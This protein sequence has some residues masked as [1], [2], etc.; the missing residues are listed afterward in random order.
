MSS[1]VYIYIYMYILTEVKLDKSYMKDTLVSS[2]SVLCGLKRFSL[3]K[4][5]FR[6]ESPH[7]KSIIWA[8]LYSDIFIDV[9]KYIYIYLHLL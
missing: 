8:K 4:T 9:Y 7:I 1:S 2:Y 5:I 3:I 6:W